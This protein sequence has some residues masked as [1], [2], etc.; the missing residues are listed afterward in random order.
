MENSKFRYLE[1]TAD[2]KFQAFGKTLEEAFMNAALATVSLMWDPSQIEPQRQH[3][4]QLTGTDLPQLLVNFLEE[5]LFL[6]DTKMFLTTTVK[7]LRISENKKCFELEAQVWGDIRSSQHEVYGDVKAITYHEM[8]I[9]END[10]FMVQVV[11]DM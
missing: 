11:V 8:Q 4:F 3:I 2:A 1:H 6:F 9:E 7:N 5:I 10:A